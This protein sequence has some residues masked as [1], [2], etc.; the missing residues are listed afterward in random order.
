MDASSLEMSDVMK[1]VESQ[2][3]TGLLTNPLYG[4]QVHDENENLRQE[5]ET[6]RAKL[7]EKDQVPTPTPL[8]GTAH[9]HGM[10]NSQWP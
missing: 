5:L 1:D 6:M 10:R 8:S 2:A 9:I 4:N 3:R 7:A